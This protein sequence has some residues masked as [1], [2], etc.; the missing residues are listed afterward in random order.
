MNNKKSIIISLGGSLIIPKEGFDIKFLRDFRKLIL[1]FAG[2][3]K[4][5]LICGG[6]STARNY[7][8]AAADVSKISREEMDWLGIDATKLNAHFVRTI[9]GAAAHRDIIA[10][11]TKKINCKEN[12]LIG[13][14]WRPGCSTDFDAVMLAETYGAKKVINLTDIDYLHDKNPKIYPDAKKIKIIDWA[15]FRKIVGDKWTP[16]ANTPFD[17]VA[18]R[19]AQKLKLELILA[20][21]KKINNLKKIIKGDKFTGS[22]VH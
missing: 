4:F 1:S 10:D 17:P 7:I 12:I 11:P 20:N 3:Y 5:I 2:N 9:F 19:A 16:G 13:A 18:T 15:G 14:G 22:V 21:G 8:K 6:G